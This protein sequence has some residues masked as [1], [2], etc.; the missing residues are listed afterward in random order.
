MR[1]E[2]VGAE[3]LFKLDRKV[4]RNQKQNKLGHRGLICLGVLGTTQAMKAVL[5][6]ET[7]Q[8]ELLHV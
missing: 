2:I 8:N 1:R 5:I 4:T 6:C 7:D 3:V